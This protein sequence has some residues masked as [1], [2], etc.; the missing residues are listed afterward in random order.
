[1]KGWIPLQLCTYTFLAIVW[2]SDPFANIEQYLT[3]KEVQ[4]IKEK[5]HEK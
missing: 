4:R 1:M 5:Q 3:E 2:L